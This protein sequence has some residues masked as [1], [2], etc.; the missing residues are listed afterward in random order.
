VK[1]YVKWIQ[2]GVKL[3]L[4]IGENNSI[5]EL[6]AISGDSLLVESA[7]KELSSPK[8]KAERKMLHA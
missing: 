4:V 3:L 2:E 7:M 5:A 8:R 6:Q 1:F